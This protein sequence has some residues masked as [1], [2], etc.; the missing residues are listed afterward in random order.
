RGGRPVEIDRLR[1]CG[2]DTA[3]WLPYIRHDHTRPAREYSRNQQSKARAIVYNAPGD[4]RIWESYVFSVSWFF[5]TGLLIP[6]AQVLW[7]AF[8]Y[9][10]GV[11]FRA[12]SCRM[13]RKLRKSVEGDADMNGLGGLNKSPEGV[14]IGLVQLQLPVD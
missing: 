5:R 2:D 4:Y 10:L 12:S 1:L 11:M 8:A 7:R 6:C 13:S 14:V 3:Q 9:S